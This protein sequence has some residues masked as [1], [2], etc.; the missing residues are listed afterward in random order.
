MRWRDCVFPLHPVYEHAY[1]NNKLLNEY[2][3]SFVVNASVGFKQI[4]SFMLDNNHEIKL[5]KK[6]KKNMKKQQR[7]NIS[8][9]FFFF[10]NR[11]GNIVARKSERYK[12][13]FVQR[14]L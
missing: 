14:L 13:V 8:F 12:I 6:Q 9:F 5:K 1:D 4:I 7:T 10:L 11:I 3:V 2:F